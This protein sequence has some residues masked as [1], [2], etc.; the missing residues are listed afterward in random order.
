MCTYCC[1]I[2]LRFAHGIGTSDSDDIQTNIQQ[3]LAVSDAEAPSTP[4]A[5]RD[6]VCLHL[7]LS[8]E[9]DYAIGKTN[10][11]VFF[12]TKQISTYPSHLTFNLI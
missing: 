3:R 7:S 6:Q 1:K 10:I 5:S 9:Y 8:E 11:C 12:V 2:V 4:V